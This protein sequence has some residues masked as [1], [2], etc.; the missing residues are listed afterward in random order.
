MKPSVMGVRRERSSKLVQ[1]AFDVPGPQAAEQLTG[2]LRR[3]LR[4]GEELPDVWMFMVLLLRWL[5]FVTK[6][7]VAADLAHEQELAN[8]KPI[9]ELRD[10]TVKQLIATLIAMRN[11][12]VSF[13]GKTRLEEIGFTEQTPRDPLT[14]LNV[15]KKLLELLGDPEFELPAPLFGEKLT[16]EPADIAEV[17]EPHA[18]VLESALDDVNEEVKKAQSTQ[19]V[20]NEK[21]EVYDTDFFWIARWL[22]ASLNLA[23]M[24]HE[25]KRVKPSIRR[26][27]RTEVEPEEGEVETEE[28]EVEPDEGEVETQTEP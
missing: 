25:A 18:V 5:V 24:K 28:V 15:A 19:A 10:A 27:G 11:A 8:D 9:R 6:E 14:I 3:H 12:C 16:L 20:K 23:G 17:V 1:K 2:R 4:E 7:M 22:E 26:R 13:Y 21:R